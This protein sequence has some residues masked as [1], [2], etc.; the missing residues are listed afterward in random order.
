MVELRVGDYISE[1]LI[2]DIEKK[3]NEISRKIENSIIEE[4][5]NLIEEAIE[6][7]Y[8]NGYYDGYEEGQNSPKY[9]W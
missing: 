9:E 4:L 5:A 6:Q 1:K 8:N 3:L 7:A 2:I